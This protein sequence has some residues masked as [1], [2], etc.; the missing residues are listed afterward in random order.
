MASSNIFSLKMLKLGIDVKPIARL[1]SQIW[2]HEWWSQKKD[3]K[4]K[5]RRKEIVKECEYEDEERDL[6]IL[7]IPAYCV[8]F[9]NLTWWEE[10]RYSNQS[11]QRVVEAGRRLEKTLLGFEMAQTQSIGGFIRTLIQLHPTYIKL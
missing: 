9:V 2:L 6:R 8:S 4:L 11:R 3:M 1:Q 7:E 5:S 10:K